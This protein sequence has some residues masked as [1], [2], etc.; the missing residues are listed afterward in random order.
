MKYPKDLFNSITFNLFKISINEKNGFY[1]V[2]DFQFF[3]Y[4]SLDNPKNE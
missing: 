3:K 4:I 1:I 2:T